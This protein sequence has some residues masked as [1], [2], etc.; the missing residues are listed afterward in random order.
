MIRGSFCAKVS[1]DRK[2]SLTDKNQGHRLGH[3][4]HS[5]GWGFGFPPLLAA[6]AA[7]AL[8]RRER[9]PRKEKD[10][11]TKSYAKSSKPDDP[12]TACCFHYIQGRHGHLGSPAL[13]PGTEKM[14]IPSPAAVHGIHASSQQFPMWD[15][16]RLSFRFSVS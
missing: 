1:R 6:G 3:R 15:M 7:A 12:E 4:H 8:R 2:R 9:I 14:A 10:F 11:Y 13:S 16:S 5:V